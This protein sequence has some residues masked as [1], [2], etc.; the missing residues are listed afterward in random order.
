MSSEA[1]SPSSLKHDSSQEHVEALSSRLSAEVLKLKPSHSKKA[2]SS[3]ASLRSMWYKWWG[4]EGRDA[5]SADRR[6]LTNT[7]FWWMSSRTSS[8]HGVRVWAAKEKT[9][10]SSDS[11][12]WSF[13]CKI[14]YL[15]VMLGRFLCGKDFGYSFV[16]E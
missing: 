15:F 8:G 6:F 4:L 16:F 13:F 11:S 12:S 3:S 1:A 9:E 7:N 14:E 2:C 5:N 10:S